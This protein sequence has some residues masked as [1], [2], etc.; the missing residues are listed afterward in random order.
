MEVK[1]E[2]AA[3][4]SFYDLEVKKMYLVQTDKGHAAVARVPT[5]EKDKDI[6]LYFGYYPADVGWNPIRLAEDVLIQEN[7]RILGEAD[8]KMNFWLK[9]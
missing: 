8:G 5:G 3:K 4:N 1:I 9:G 6:I 7:W 2:M